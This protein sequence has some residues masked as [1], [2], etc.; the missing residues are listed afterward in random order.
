MRNARVEAPV[1]YSQILMRQS[2]L[3]APRDRA[4]FPGFAL[5]TALIR[6]ANHQSQTEPP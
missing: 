6:N 3:F 2:A 5:N 1:S 4:F